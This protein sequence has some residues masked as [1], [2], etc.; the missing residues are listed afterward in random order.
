MIIRIVI[1]TVTVTSTAFA[2]PIFKDTDEKAWYYQSVSELAGKK[3]ISGYEDNTFKPANNVKV[4]E[5]IKMLTNAMSL[6]SKSVSSGHWALGCYNTAKMFGLIQDGELSE[7]DLDKD[8]TRGQMAR[9]L[10]RALNDGKDDN[11]EQYKTE[12][13]DYITIT[14]EYKSHVLKAYGLGLLSGYEDGTFRYSGILNRAEACAV[15]VRFMD[16][17]DKQVADTQKTIQSPVQNNI[18]NQ[19]NVNITDNSGNSY[20][21]KHSFTTF[22]YAGQEFQRGP[23]MTLEIKFTY[24][25]NNNLLYVE[26]IRGADDYVVYRQYPDGREEYFL[27]APAL[28][29]K[30]IDDFNDKYDPIKQQERREKETANIIK[31]SL[32][33]R[34]AFRNELIKN[35]GLTVT[36]GSNFSID[37]YLTPS[38]DLLYMVRDSAAADYFGM[39]D[40]TEK[41]FFEDTSKSVQKMSDL[42]KNM[43]FK[44]SLKVIIIP[45]EC[46][47]N[48]SGVFIPDI[49]VDDDS[50][51]QMILFNNKMSLE[52]QFK[53]QLEEFK[54]V[55]K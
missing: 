46:E 48:L 17:K 24:A 55:N 53:V 43:T 42:L 45:Y 20:I 3:I 12:I 32:D 33:K 40:V 28:T 29:K 37:N 52:E 26:I 14:D 44:K 4:G 23:E 49:T 39:L 31:N 38:L 30:Q 5:F 15:I 36:E 19:S 25:G 1:T 51:Y 8:I 41:T 10:V 27:P 11:L 21:L 2:T 18:N 13:K 9:M 47:K 6:E 34:A 54:K 22:P 7:N 35:K 50:A 16:L